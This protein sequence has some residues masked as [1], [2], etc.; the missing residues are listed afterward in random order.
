MSASEST[1]SALM[2]LSSNS[3]LQI[4]HG[5]DCGGSNVRRICVILLTINRAIE[6]KSIKAEFSLSG[7]RGRILIYTLYRF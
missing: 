4:A 3:P 6:F 5:I 1:L 7:K 2:H